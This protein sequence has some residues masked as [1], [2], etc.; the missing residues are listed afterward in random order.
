L[1]E[2]NDRESDGDGEGRGGRGCIGIQSVVRLK[3]EDE[4]W[5]G[6]LDMVWGIGL[7]DRFMFIGNAL[8]YPERQ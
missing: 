6:S 1:R 3:T 5:V 8:K 7:C 2:G 4:G